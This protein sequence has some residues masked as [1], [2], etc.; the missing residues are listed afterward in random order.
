[1][2]VSMRNTQLILF[3][4]TVNSEI[5]ARVCFRETSHMRSFVK[6]KSSRNG[7]ITAS[8][9]DIGKS[10][11]DRE[12][13]T[14]IMNATRENKILAKIS[15]STVHNFTYTTLVDISSQQTFLPLL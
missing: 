14:S 12:Y 15:E 1:M 10:C 4:D 13:F 7:K 3:L 8:F 6:K 11:C 5:F 2:L 9:I